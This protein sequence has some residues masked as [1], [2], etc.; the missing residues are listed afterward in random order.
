MHSGVFLFVDLVARPI[1]VEK[2]RKVNP[3]DLFIKLIQ[4]KFAERVTRLRCYLLSG[5]KGLILVAW[6][7]I[8]LLVV[9][10]NRLIATF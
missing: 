5:W 6:H 7:D 1:C 9:W 8:M 10:R 3:T 2:L 4:I